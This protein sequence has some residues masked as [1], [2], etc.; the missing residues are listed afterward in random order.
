MAKILSVPL[1]MDKDR[2]KVSSVWQVLMY[3][4]LTWV[5]LGFLLGRG[6]IFGDIWPFGLAFLA[7]WRGSKR[8]LS[9]PYVL[10]GVLAGITSIVDFR[11]ALPYYAAFSLIWFSPSKSKE[12]S[13]CWLICSCILI[14]MPLHY[15]LQ[16]V[17]MVYIA[18]ITECVLAVFSYELLYALLSQSS[19]EKSCRDELQIIFIIITLIISINWRYSGFSPRLLLT[20]FLI[21]I[22][23]RLGGLPFASIAGTAL[24]LFSL[25]LGESTHFVLLL[26]V[27]G[28]LVGILSYFKW[29]YFVGPL[30]ALIAVA[31]SPAG[32]ETVQWLFVLMLAAVVGCLVPEASLKR[33]SRILPGTVRYQKQT[34]SEEKYVKKAFNEKID[35]YL[36]VLKELEVSLLHDENTLICDQMQ[37]I[38][39]LLEAM[40]IS[41]S[42]KSSFTKELE[43][44]ILAEFSG[45]DLTYATVLQTLDGYKIHGALEEPC[46]T[47]TV[48]QEIADFCSGTI[49]SQRYM[50]STSNCR[51]E[52]FCSF[53]ITP[54]PRY[55]VE[56]GKAKV[57][58][59]EISGDSQVAFEISDSK[60]AIVISDGMGVGKKAHAESNVTVRLLERMLKAGYNLAT[61][62]SSINRLLMLRNP[63]EMF[64]TIDLVVV[65]LFSGDLEFAKI[66]AAPSFIKRGREVEI[67]HNHC[68]PVGVLAQVDIQTDRRKLREGEVLV[69]STDG[70][71][72]AQR[73][74]ARKDEWMCWN[75]R[76]LHNSHDPA[77]LAEEVLKQRLDVAHG[78]VVDDMMVVV[79]R[80]VRVDWDI[81]VYR[82]KR[83]SGL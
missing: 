72:D 7:A 58:Q 39:E 41:F 1:G 30:L 46:S 45:A 53:T 49:E 16:P 71:L 59:E 3:S 9:K 5:M 60:L 38:S 66:G 64:V 69:M 4:P 50:V 61:T 65:D 22:G 51:K 28:L 68:L 79:A 76:R 14:K 73:N 12:F 78:E 40:K 35:Q 18:S 42:P 6:A 47:R 34:Q 21:I 37:G 74:I 80:L 62:V 29:G 24:A 25:L 57:A 70:V 20:M 77:S 43:G 83:S 17:F 32:P 63:E 81:D 8:K 31:P 67:V 75:L 11:L 36:T 2:S 15:F 10:F 55:R 44:K 52:G 56:I 33:L 19:E 82:R 26:V 48:C 54:R 23:T 27:S 13:K